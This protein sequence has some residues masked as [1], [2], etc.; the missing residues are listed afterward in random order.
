MSNKP[1]FD[2]DVILWGHGSSIG[3]SG[4]RLL[5]FEDHFELIWWDASG[6]GFLGVVSS[7]SDIPWNE[8]KNKVSITSQDSIYYNQIK[9]I[10]FNKG[11][12]GLSPKI[13][14]QL[15]DG[16]EIK[17]S[18]RYSDTGLQVKNYIQARI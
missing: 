16:K 14:I 7:S 1:A 5:V 3:N 18:T 8:L 10:E 9:S 12:L 17:F 6:E 2:Y 13:K 4:E 11:F 15:K